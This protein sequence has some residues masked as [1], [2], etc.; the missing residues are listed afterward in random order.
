MINQKTPWNGKVGTEQRL[1]EAA[2]E[3][4]AECGYQSATTRQICERAGANIAAIN[5]HFGDKEGLYMAVLR[6]VPKAYADKY[7]ADFGLTAGAT[8]EQKLLAYLRSL[9]HRVFDEGRPGW[10]TKLISR[11]M[12]EPTRALDSLVEEAARPVHEELAS[13]VRELLGL[14]ATEEAIRQCT[15]SIISQ[16]VYYHHARAVIRRLYP[17]Q[18]YGV[19]DIDR[20]AEHVAKFSLAALKEFSKSTQS[21]AR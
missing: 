10:H 20:L 7:P 19:E 2:G 15:L 18:Q 8:A 4:F 9:L 6:S 11:E 12:I 17:E 21:Q 13:I 1:L 14:E 16:C 3:I 5:Y